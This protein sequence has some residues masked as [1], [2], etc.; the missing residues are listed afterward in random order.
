MIFRVNP[1]NKFIKHDSSWHKTYSFTHPP[2]LT[3]SRRKHNP[4]LDD[5]TMVDLPNDPCIPPNVS[6]NIC[7][8]CNSWWQDSIKSSSVR[9]QPRDLFCAFECFSWHSWQTACWNSPLFALKHMNTQYEFL[10]NWITWSC[11]N[12]M[13]LQSFPTYS[14]FVPWSCLNVVVLFMVVRLML[15]EGW[16]LGLGIVIY[17]LKEW[18]KMTV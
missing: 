9:T 2:H 17:G 11:L 12:V 1:Y 8:L 5:Q 7:R 10:F 13:V 18:H 3:S 14:P 16:S 15:W 4:L 6:T